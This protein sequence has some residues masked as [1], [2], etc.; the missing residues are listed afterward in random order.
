MQGKV[1]QKL[2]TLG[3]VCLVFICLAFFAYLAMWSARERASNELKTVIS[4]IIHRSALT[5]AQVDE[6]LRAQRI[7]ALI[8]C[9][10]DHLALMQS[11]LLKASYLKGLAFIQA[12]RMLCSTLPDTI[13]QTYLGPANHTTATGSRRWNRME[14]PDAPHTTFVITELDGY[15][16]IIAPGL[17]LDVGGGSF[18]NF[19]YT[20]S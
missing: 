3:A 7:A 13:A 17:V 9:S 8:P 10:S 20:L 12:D 11:E 18:R 15:A 16:A 2:A 1:M 6:A 19:H 4:E 5:Q 14:L